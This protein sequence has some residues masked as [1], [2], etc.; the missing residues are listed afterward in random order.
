M[1]KFLNDF[2]SF[3]MKGNVLNLVVAVIIGAA[4]GKII[5]SLVK[6]VLMPIISLVTGGGGFENYKYVISTADEV[7]G[8][9]ENAIYYGMFIQNIIDFVIIAFVVFLIVKLF[10]KANDLANQKRIEEEIAVK[11]VEE[12]KKKEQTAL[13]AKKPKIED[14]LVD[15]KKLLEKNLNKTTN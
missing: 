1:K 2:K 11:L 10:N 4:F 6:D 7:N 8:V 3:M 12:E 15:I 9:A 5:S 14:L 13:D